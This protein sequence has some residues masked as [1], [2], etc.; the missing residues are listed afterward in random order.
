M[1]GGET[2]TRGGKAGEGAQS[3][4]KHGGFVL[5]RRRSVSATTERKNRGASVARE[6]HF[7]EGERRGG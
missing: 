6:E 7:E 2:A 4:R 3:R 5:G 1:K